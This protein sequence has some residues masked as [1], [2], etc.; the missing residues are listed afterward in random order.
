MR[1]LGVAIGLVLLAGLTAPASAQ[2]A[3]PSSGPPSPNGRLGPTNSQVPVFIT[4]PNPTGPFQ[5][6]PQGTPG[7]R[8]TFPFIDEPHRLNNPHPI[9]RNAGLGHV[10]SRVW[11]APR[12]VW[13]QVYVPAPEGIPAK[14][15]TMYTEVPG[16]YV[17]QTTTGTLYPERWVIDHLNVGLYQWRKAPAQFVPR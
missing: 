9:L 4:R 2:L 8:E 5:E 10:V 11:V 6:V 12:P 3:P 13:M 14:Y 16:F 1:A 15:Q 17:V 7:S